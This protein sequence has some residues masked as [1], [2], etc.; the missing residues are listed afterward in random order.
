MMD[1]FINPTKEILYELSLDI[2]NQLEEDANLNE[3]LVN[4]KFLE[5]INDYFEIL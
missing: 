4:K 5:T 3:E 2:Y 1:E